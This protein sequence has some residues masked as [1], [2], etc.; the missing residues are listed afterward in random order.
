MGGAPTAGSFLIDLR[1][2]FGTLSGGTDYSMIG[3]P[4]SA[5]GMQPGETKL[6]PYTFSKDVTAMGRARL[7]YMIRL[8]CTNLIAESNEENN[9]SPFFYI[10]PPAER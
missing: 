2:A 4:V 6:L 1:S 7:P 10:T 8:D 5:G 9:A 3:E